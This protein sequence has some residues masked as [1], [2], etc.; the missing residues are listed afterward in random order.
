VTTVFVTGG[1]GFVGG[2]LIQRLRAEDHDVRALARS[3]R[4]VARVR[5]SG[6]E[7]V[8]GD[9]SDLAA[10]MAGAQ[11][12]EWAFHAAANVQD[13]GAPEDFVRDNVDGTRNALQACEA[14]GVRRFVHVGTEAGLLVGQPLVNADESAPLRPDSP[15][16]Y[17]STKARAERLAL[18]ANREGF[19]TVVIRP[20]W[21]WGPD[22]T[23]LL[24]RLVE[25]VR[26]GGFRWIGGGRQRQSTTHVDN[27][28]DALML[29]VTRGAPGNAY[30]VTDGDPVVFREFIA[31]LLATQGVDPP[32][33]NIP[34]R[35]AAAIAG[36][37][38]QAWRAFRLPGRPP[39]TRFSVW[40]SS[41]ECTLNDAKAREQLGYRPAKSR[42]EGLAELRAAAKP[43]SH[44]Q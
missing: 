8:R 37:G 4:S 19:E 34:R 2:K 7:P 42:D 16:L 29:G 21:V 1:S 9:L 12:C 5:Q 20:R 10:M 26:T 44:A 30:F 39:M 33:R 38:E 18:D 3:E 43:A 41:L 22:D 36:I 27:L 15:V 13:W 23:V 25:Q 31:E 11:G 35:V 32:T 14:A 6:A 40:Y 17:S 28:V 24:P